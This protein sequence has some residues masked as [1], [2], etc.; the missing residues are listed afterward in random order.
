MP[1]EGRNGPTVFPSY[2]SF[3]KRD[4]DGAEEANELERDI[5]GND[6]YGAIRHLHRPTMEYRR[7]TRYSDLTDEEHRYLQRVQWRT[8]FNLANANLVGIKNFRSHGPGRNA[9]LAK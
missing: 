1:E 7:Y 2:C 3:F 5:V 6:L 4:T 8:F 9:D